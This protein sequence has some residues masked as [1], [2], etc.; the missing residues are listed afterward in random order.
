M[1]HNASRLENLAEVREADGI[2]A[3]SLGSLLALQTLPRLHQEVPLLAL[4]PIAWFCHPELGWPVRVL[5]RMGSQIRKDPRAV[6]TSFAEQMGP[7]SPDQKK[8]WIESA[9]LI[10][11]DDL[12]LGL[13][14]LANQSAS[15][16]K[17][18][19]THHPIHLVIGGQ[20]GV[21]SPE[22][23]IWLERE[24]VQPKSLQVL[25]EM[26]HWPFSEKW[27]LPF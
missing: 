19:A 1:L 21:V 6:L 25:P 18:L 4:C 23:A 11:V 14:I 9:L 7:N 13:Q 17:N 12:E 24:L 3:W 8:A 2:V 27:N 26:S 20:D 16:L 10:P 22:L 15:Q 5:S